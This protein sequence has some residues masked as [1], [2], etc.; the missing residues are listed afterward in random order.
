MLKSD[1]ITYLLPV[2]TQNL[3]SID[4]KVWVLEEDELNFFFSHICR[5]LTYLEFKESLKKESIDSLDFSAESWELTSN[6]KII[7]LI[8]T[9]KNKEKLVYIF[10][11]ILHES[12]GF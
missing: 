9:E 1:L 4:R 12:N 2:E 3:I 11:N 8:I 7:G 5:N 10:S 6:K